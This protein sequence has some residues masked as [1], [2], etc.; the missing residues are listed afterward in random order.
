M[1]LSILQGIPTTAFLTVGSLAIGMIGGIP[2]VLA[3][4]SRFM[5]LRWLARTWIEF[6][7]GIPPI[8]WL[9]IVFFG[10]GGS[11]PNLSPLVAAFAALGFISSAFMAEIYRGGLS[12][13]HSGQAEAAHALGMSNLDIGVRVVGPQVFRISVPAAATYGI[14]LLKDT[15]IAYTIGVNDVLSRA[16]AESRLT[17]DALVP[18]LLAA[19]A[20]IALTIP[21]AYGARRLETTL[22]KRVIR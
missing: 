4:R 1:F 22:T 2:L 19:V 13:V 9:F 20:Y 21:C 7:R 8:V 15:S 12:G 17:A 10:I 3:R 5:A 16:S 14:A 18:F 11:M 6:G